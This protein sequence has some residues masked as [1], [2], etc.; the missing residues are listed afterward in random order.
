MPGILDPNYDL[1]TGKKRGKN[2]NNYNSGILGSVPS[3]WGDSKSSKNNSSSFD[4]WGNR[5]DNRKTSNEKPL[6]KKVREDVWIEYIGNSMVGKCYV[7][8]RPILHNHFEA[9]HIVSR[10]NGGSDEIK[11]LR[12]ICGSCNR[13][14]GTRGMKEYA[15][16]YYG[17]SI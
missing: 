2:K 14:M 3:I 6:P 15:K 8:R 11:N 10:A 5:A 4:L 13:S 9:G 7:C 1:W 16:K 12:P 17:R